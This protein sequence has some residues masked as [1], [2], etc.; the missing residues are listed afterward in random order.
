MWINTAQRRTDL[1]IMD[2]LEMDGDQLIDSLDHIARINQWLG[3]NRLTIKALQVLL[4]DQPRDTEL[5]IVDLGCGNGDML[6]VIAAM[7]RKKG[8]RFRLLGIDANQTTIDYAIQLSADYPEIEY[9]SE[10]VLSPGFKEIKYDIALCTLF[11][12]HFE[13]EVALEFVN[14]IVENSRIG[15]VVNDLHRHPMAWYLFNLITL[16]MNNKMAR[17]DGLLSIL[18][19]F[20]KKDLELFADKINGQST[21]RWRWAFRYQWLITKSTHPTATQL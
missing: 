15:V 20:K 10:N 5:T 13:N 3:G 17:E 8:Y 21:I 6:R 2:D 11:L 7:G 18:K 14:T 1:E 4:K 12:H 19:G 9:L 16:G